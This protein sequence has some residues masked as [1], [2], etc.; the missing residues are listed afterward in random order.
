[1]R[2]AA[3]ESAFNSPNCF[4]RWGNGVRGITCEQLIISILKDRVFKKFY[5]G[6]TEFL[7]GGGKNKLK[8]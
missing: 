7:Q 8:G 2:T 3:P 5:T 1:M 4:P 6:K